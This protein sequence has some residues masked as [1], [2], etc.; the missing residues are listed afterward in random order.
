MKIR[1]KKLKRKLL[2]D[3]LGYVAYNIIILTIAFFF[4][5]F[6]Q[7]L[8]FILMF[9]M[10]RKGFN[11]TFHANTIYPDEPIKAGK[12]CKLITIGV[13]IIYLIFCKEL[14]VSVYSNL[15]VIFVIATINALLQF[16]LER[17]L[18]S[19]ALLKN[20]EFILTKGNEVGLSTTAINRLILRY[21]EG[22]SIKEIA[23]IE[24]LTEESV[25]Q[26]L[27]RSKR[28]LDL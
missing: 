23:S 8:M 18:N 20:R 28:K 19:K 16:Y 1:S 27:R 25:K 12:V 10:I 9:G 2:F 11:Y 3:F 4:E 21:V 7:M 17:V 5:R 13:E 14:N 26:S 24:C 22:K 15:F 6:V